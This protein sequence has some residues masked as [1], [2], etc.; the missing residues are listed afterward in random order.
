MRSVAQKPTSHSSSAAT[1]SPRPVLLATSMSASSSIARRKC[2]DENRLRRADHVMHAA[3]RHA[4]QRRQVGAGRFAGEQ[5]TANLRDEGADQRRRLAA[6]V[7]QPPEDSDRLRRL[8]SGNGVLKLVDRVRAR[9]GDVLDD[10]VRADRHSFS[11]RD[12]QPLERRAQSPRGRPRPARRAR[13]P[14]PVRCHARGGAPRRRIQAPS[15][16][17]RGA[18]NSIS[19][20]ARAMRS[21]SLMRLSSFSSQKT[22]V[23]LRRRSHRERPRAPPRRLW[24]AWRLD[25]RRSPRPDREAIGSA[26]PRERRALWPRRRSSEPCSARRR[27]LGESPRERRL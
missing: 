25:A 4:E 27:R 9:R 1:L 20:P 2:A 6:F 16:S 11:D 17:P 13:Q 24:P 3:G 12:R 14:H 8:P 19:A 22:I 21:K 15:L 5:Q 26:A 10:G 23:G 7:E 18:A